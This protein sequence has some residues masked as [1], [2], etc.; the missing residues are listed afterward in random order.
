MLCMNE[1]DKKFNIESIYTPLSVAKK[2]IWKRWNNKELRKK[3]E[4]F[5]GGDVPEFLK[6]EPR[7]CLGRNI[8]SPNFETKYF[9]DL[10][11]EIDLFPIFIEHTNDKFVAKNPDKYYLVRL[12]FHNGNGKNKGD[13]ISALNAIDFNKYQG[14]EI[15]KIETLWGEK[16][17]NFHHKILKDI[18]PNISYDIFDISKILN[19]KNKKMTKQYDKYLAL[20][21]CGGVLFENFLLNKGLENFAFEVVMPAVL[22][23]E[24]KFG[25]KPLIVPLSPMDEQSNL[26]WWCYP[27]TIKKYCKK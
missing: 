7:A 15:K 26:Y 9:I 11:N 4:D 22:K 3:V 27:E 23:L 2:E 8:A 12:Y 25:I 19:L 21:L 10:A 16:L 6:D 13:K 1:T 24:K 17:V 20:F 5:L 18:F 14:K